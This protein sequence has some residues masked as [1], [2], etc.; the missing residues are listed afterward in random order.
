MAM[1]VQCIDR[2]RVKSG[3]LPVYAARAMAKSYAFRKMEGVVEVGDPG[4]TALKRG[5]DVTRHEHHCVRRE[6]PMSV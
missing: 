4:E 3:M 6:K 2:T 5:E 1:A